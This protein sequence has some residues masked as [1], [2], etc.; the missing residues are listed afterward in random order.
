MTAV[1][2][3]TRSAQSKLSVPDCTQCS[4]GVTLASAPPWRKLR[5]TG[6]DSAHEANSAPVVSALTTVL[7]S[8]RLPSPPTIAASSGRKTIRRIGCIK[9]DPHHCERRAAIQ[10]LA[11]RLGLPRDLRS[12]AM[13]NGEGTYLPLHP[14]DVIDRDR[15]AATEVDDQDRQADR[16]LAGGHGQYEHRKNLPR[17]VLEVGAEGDEVDVHRQQDQL[18]RHQDDDHVLAVQKNPQHAK[19]EQDRADDDVVFDPD[20]SFTPW[21]TS[22][23]T[24][25]VAS[26]GRREF[27]LLTFW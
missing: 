6:Q 18:D 17:Q 26:C 27:C 13:T 5:K 16:G 2:V 3:S 10:C 22:G 9:P 19:H 8:M 4:T 24:L 20:H 25:R 21:P 1:N 12:L 11:H 7:P 14:V 23:F 15:T